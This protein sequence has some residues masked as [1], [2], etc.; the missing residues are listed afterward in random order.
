[1]SDHPTRTVP[2]GESTAV[3]PAG[4]STGLDPTPLAPPADP[5]APPPGYEFVA[6]VGRGGMGVVYQARDL[7]LDRD[8]A[9][10]LL[11]ERYA[12]DS[13]AARRF[14]DEARITG[15]LQHPGIPAVHQVGT[16]PDDRPFLAMKLIKGRT[17]D[18]F[19]NERA[20][21]A[22]ERGRLLAVFEKV[23]EAV[24]YAHAHGVIHRDLKP[25]NVMVGAFGEVQV[26][27]W[28]LAKVLT[29]RGGDPPGP[30]PDAT[31]LGTEIHSARGEDA[32]TQ[33]GSL[34]GTPAY[35]PPEQA[36]G[37]VDQ[38][39]TRS[40]VFGLG[41]VLC[42]VLTGKPP[43]VG[44]TAESTRQMAAR[45]RLDDAHARLN[46]C[47]AEPELVALCRRCLSP[48]PADRPRHAGEV[49]DAVQRLR[50]DAED[51]ARRAELH[52]ARAEVQAAEQ[53]KRR[54]VQ[55]ALAAAVGL[56]LTGGGVF[57]WW[58]DR[59]AAQRR[60]QLARNTD[61]LADLVGRCEEALRENDANG[62]AVALDQVDRRLPE[63]GGEAMTDRVAR[64]RAD[65]AMLRE[66][67]AVDTFRWTLVGN[68]FPDRTEV[69]AR[70]R[71]AFAGYGVV[72]DGAQASEVAGRLSGS[73]IPGRLLAALDLWLVLSPSPGVR[74]VLRAADPDVYR[75]AVRDAVAGGNR[76]RVAELAGRPEALAQPPGFA[77]ALGQHRAVPTERRRAV[78]G[79]ALR[80]RP[81]DLSLLMTLGLSYSDTRRGGSGEAVRWFQAAVAAHPR[82]SSAHNSLGVALSDKGDPDGAI[83]SYR[84]AIRLDTRNAGAHNNLGAVL[85]DDKRDYDGAA[86]C[87]R[88]AIRLDPGHALAHSNLGNALRSQGDVD[89]AIACYREAIRLEPKFVLPHSGLGYALLAKRDYDGAIASFREATRVDPKFTNAHIN[90]GFVLGAKGDADGA[91][92]SYREALRLDPENAN[93]HNQ[94]AW[95]LATGPD[96]VR[97]GRRAVEH[98]TR[99]CEL[100]GWKNPVYIDTLAASYA[101]TG[102]FGKAV[103]YQKKALA[104]PG[105]EKAKGA[106]PRR[107]LDLYVQKA[108]YRH[109]APAAAKPREVAPPPRPALRRPALNWLT[110]D[111]AAWRKRLADDPAGNRDAVHRTMAHWLTD[112]D[113]ASVRERTELEKLPLD[114]RVGWVKLWTEVRELRDA[115]APPEVA[116]PPRPA[117]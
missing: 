107:R 78:L 27:D 76:D 57:A 1:M 84:E 28:G 58:A 91:A 4:D 112:A 30:D 25:A 79:A 92:A 89:G 100:T 51:R 26:M 54:K 44:D 66:L 80:P 24:G 60:E 102:D 16:L 113:L 85:H 13:F 50:A 15:Q 39:D 19:L 68:K 86:A 115:T 32:A 14:L 65:L 61:A 97:D 17:L 46:T 37:A 83:A 106:A 72:P 45:T 63:G 34:L 53:R 64:C 33:A 29:G 3:P 31:T 43:Y 71:V 88:E 93:A 94:L 87:F 8:V 95:L 105:F 41:G 67:D 96:G 109:P 18:E 62:A 48:E 99:A 2:T 104:V 52:R 77:A 9:V 5:P 103:E 12:P 110:A 38:I 59:Q 73:L 56:A 114:E 35:M 23:C 108:P 10:K 42:A 36:I 111:L 117:K 55:L 7:S 90:L 81:G 74:E 116:P 20:D 40:D 49:A 47:G 75:D 70:Y 21:P 101:E 98:A 69:A 22:A 6:E 82:S 11:A